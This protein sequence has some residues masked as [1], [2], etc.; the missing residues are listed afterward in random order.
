MFF[1]ATEMKMDT[2][3]LME[4][5]I[6]TEATRANLF[7]CLLSCIWIKNIVKLRISTA[8]F[9]NALSFSSRNQVEIKSIFLAT[10]WS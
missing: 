3:R 7:P 1:F 6:T 5:F 4:P 2:G 9:N 8:L 10:E